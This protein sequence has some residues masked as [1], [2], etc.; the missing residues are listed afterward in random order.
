MVREDEA[1]G[2]GSDAGTGKATVAAS[3]GVG[4]VGSRA[5][6]LYCRT[7]T[8]ETAGTHVA[9]EQRV[10]AWA[11]ADSGRGWWEW[12][13]S[14]W[15]GSDP[16]IDICVGAMEADPELPHVPERRAAAQR[17]S[18]DAEMHEISSRSATSG[19]AKMA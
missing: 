11:D 14:A 15:D 3:V 10:A 9:C 6:R 8:N 19:A 12:Q 1:E 17:A 4:T 5:F 13:G 2:S 7:G 18:H 16:D